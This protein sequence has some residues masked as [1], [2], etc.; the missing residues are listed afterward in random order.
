VFTLSLLK[1][2]C[3]L[4]IV[5]PATENSL[6]LLIKVAGIANRGFTSLLEQG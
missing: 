3:S 4:V 1:L 5:K 2:L 6:S